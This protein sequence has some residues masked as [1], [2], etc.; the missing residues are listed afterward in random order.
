M[1]EDEQAVR[2]AFTALDEA[3]ERRDLDA[4]L[5]LC[6]DDVVFIGSGHGEEAV[7]R[8]AIAPM[9]AALAPQLEGG[10]WSLTW[11]SID[12][13]VLGD[14]ALLLA[15]GKARLVTQR[16][17]EQ[18]FRYRFTGVLVRSGDEWLWRVHHGSEPGAW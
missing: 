18:R 10:E 15:W 8:D 5:A 2:D 16:R 4:A 1:N 6:T 11:D 14:V 17:G 3:F 7:G 13:D 12:V 9:F